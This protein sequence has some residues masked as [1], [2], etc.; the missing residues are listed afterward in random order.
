M[1]R[2]KDSIKKC[3]RIS[4]TLFFQITSYNFFGPLCT[5]IYFWIQSTQQISI[6]LIHTI[7]DHII[8]RPIFSISSLWPATSS[9]IYW[10]SS[11][12]RR[13]LPSL[14][15]YNYS[16]HPPGGATGYPSATGW[17]PSLSR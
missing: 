2:E 14:S 15:R 13:W 3:F 9:W 4:Q 12:Y 10:L 16:Q 17:I 11:S 7:H 1:Y 5:C 8:F 6:F